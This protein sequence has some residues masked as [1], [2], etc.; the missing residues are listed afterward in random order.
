M[1]KIASYKL[2]PIHDRKKWNQFIDSCILKLK[3]TIGY[4]N[5]CGRIALFLA[6]N[7]L[8]ETCFC[9]HCHSQNRQ[10]QMAFILLHMINQEKKLGVFSSIRSIDAKF[11]IWVTDTIS[12]LAT[13][14]RKTLGNNLYMSE[15][16][17]EKFESGAKVNG[18]LHIDMRNTH[19]DDESLKFILSGDVIEHIPDYHRALQETYRVL[20]Y[21][22]AHIFTVPFYQHQ[23]IIDRRAEIIDGELIR[24]KKD[25]MHIDALRPEGILCYNVFAPELLCE[26][27]KIGFQSNLYLIFNPL[28]GIYGCDGL[29]IV[30]KKLR[31]KLADIDFIFDSSEAKNAGI[32]ICNT[33]TKK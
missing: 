22:G 33:I 3:F 27:E 23:S 16:F 8:R 13:F 2:W 19:F 4:C 11:K 12:P 15:F 21:G 1:D 29:V 17:D 31:K 6:K 25:W 30:A 28:Y 7:P 9:S 32:S 20:E 18:V 14:L 26:L 24:H 10:R 5:I